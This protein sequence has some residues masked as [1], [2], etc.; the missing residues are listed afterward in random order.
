MSFELPSSPTWYLIQTK[1]KK[2]AEAFRNLC[3]LGLECFLPTMLDRKFCHGRY[4][5]TEKPLFSSYLFVK[6]VLSKHYYKIKWTKGVKCFVG[7]ADR[8]TAI[9]DEVV[10]NI[11]RQMNSQGRVRIGK[12]LRPGEK[13]RIR[14]DPLKNLIGI[15]DSKVSARGRARILLQLQLVS[16]QASVHLH[17]ALSERIR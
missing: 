17:K 3:K 12:D 5:T 4:R 15:F 2:E 8:P 14:S 7:W 1:P 16:N 6:L 9:A 13:V 11:R 10:E